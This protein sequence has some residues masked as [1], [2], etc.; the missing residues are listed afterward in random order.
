M[1]TYL[2]HFL[3]RKETKR[4][5]KKLPSLE[6]LETEYMD[7]VLEITN[8]NLEKTAH[9]LNVSPAFLFNRLEKIEVWL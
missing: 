8:N 9:I 3:Q 1:T 5:D 7:Y 2:Q 6:E 4:A